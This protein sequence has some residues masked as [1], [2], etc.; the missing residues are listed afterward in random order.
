MI[1]DFPPHVRDLQERLCAF[2]ET[3]IYPNQALYYQQSET[4]GPW[5]VAPIVEEL[6][7]LA[8]SAGLWNLFLPPLRA[9][10]R[11]FQS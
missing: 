2:M 5:K 11:S 6:K 8:R 10:S 9:W 4:L 1:L 7:P 3:H